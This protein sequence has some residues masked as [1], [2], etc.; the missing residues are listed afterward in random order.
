MMEQAI[1]N[2]LLHKLL[3]VKQQQET[4]CLV[5]GLGSYCWQFYLFMGRL[6]YAT[7][8]V[9]PVRRWRRLGSQYLP[10]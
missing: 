5:L 9:H 8:G 2:P 1:W 6:V 4:G 7:G 10:G 3:W